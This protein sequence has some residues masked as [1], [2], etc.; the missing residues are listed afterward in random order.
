MSEA[1]HNGAATPGAP[2]AQRNQDVTTLDAQTAPEAQMGTQMSEKKKP[3]KKPY[4]GAALTYP[5]KIEPRAGKLL[6]YLGLILDEY[7]YKLIM[8]L[9][10][11]E[12]RRQ[13]VPLPPNLEEALTS[14]EKDLDLSPTDLGK[15]KP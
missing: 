10:A 2:D 5:V 8:K 12:I 9:V 4:R 11:K 13:G 7:S 15:L 6:E 3:G 14:I 1:H